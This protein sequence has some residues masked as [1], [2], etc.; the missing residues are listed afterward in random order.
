MPSIKPGRKRSGKTH[1][2]LFMFR[3]LKDLGP[4]LKII[5]GKS[6]SHIVIKE[7]RRIILSD[8]AGRSCPYVAPACFASL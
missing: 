4:S 3:R 5:Q 8:L 6:R 7:T 2:L 1:N